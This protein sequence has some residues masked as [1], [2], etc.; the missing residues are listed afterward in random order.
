[1]PS[2]DIDELKRAIDLILTHIQKDLGE[3]VIDFDPETSLYWALPLNAVHDMDQTPSAASLG[4]G[5]A[6]DD[7]EFLLSMLRNA[8]SPGDAP[9]LMLE[10][11]AGVLNYLAATVRR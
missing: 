4:I 9:A 7:A 10:H 8:K 3:T 5:N 11:A 2:V 6:A 1:M